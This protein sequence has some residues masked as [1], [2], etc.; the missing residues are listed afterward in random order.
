MRT[1]HCEEMNEGTGARSSS[2]GSW[3]II[4]TIVGLQPSELDLQHHPGRSL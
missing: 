2:I 1:S 3:A 4:R